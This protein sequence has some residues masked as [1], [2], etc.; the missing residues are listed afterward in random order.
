MVGILEFQDR[1]ALEAD[2]IQVLAQRRWPEGYLCVG[3]GGRQSYQLK[4]RP[5]VFECA[6]CGRQHSVTAGTVFHRTRTSLRKWFLAAWWMGRDKRGV[7]ALFLSWELGLRYETAWLMAHKLRHALTAPTP[8]PLDG[9]VEVDE[10]YYGGRGKS[11]SRGRGRS[12]ANKSLLV[13]ALE[14][15]PV[16]AGK[17]IKGSGFIAGRARLA[18]LASAS[19]KALEPFV[20]ATVSSASQL[21]TDGFAGYRKLGET[22]DHQPVVQGKGQ[23]AEK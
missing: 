12:N 7:S 23:N 1:Y 13:M 19:G 10:S 18:V 8:A 20:R 21:Q 11:E 2:C 3:C 6:G 14:K 15:R 9:L 4:S 16:E 17:G 22:Y 5:R